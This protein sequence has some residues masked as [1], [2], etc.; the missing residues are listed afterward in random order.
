MSDG[1]RGRG[2]D[3]GATALQGFSTGA[4]HGDGSQASHFLNGS[5][6]LVEIDEVPSYVG[7]ND[8]DGSPLP[9]TTGISP[10]TN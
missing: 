10:N 6:T 1:D 9:N 5:N 4:A 7:T 2:L 8:F 3:G